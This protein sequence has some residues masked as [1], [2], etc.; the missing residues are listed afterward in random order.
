MK[1]LELSQTKNLATKVHYVKW[2]WAIKPSF[3]NNENLY[4]NKE[5]KI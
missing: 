4:K 3:L 5:G 2:I 1:N